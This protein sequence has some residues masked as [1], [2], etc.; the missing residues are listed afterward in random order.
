MN[1]KDMLDLLEGHDWDREIKLK[2]HDGS[3]K[4]IEGFN[5]RNTCV[6][7]DAIIYIVE[8]NPLRIKY[9]EEI[10]EL[11]DFVANIF[12]LCET[13]NHR[14]YAK[15]R[16]DWDGDYIKTVMIGL[17][18][19]MDFYIKECKLEKYVEKQLGYYEEGCGGEDEAFIKLNVLQSFIL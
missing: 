8:R 12:E 16:D 10:G 15:Y 19:E 7:G 2:L 5:F 14:G 6:G 4:E 9:E 11:I 17:C 1:V 13:E 18:K 3:I